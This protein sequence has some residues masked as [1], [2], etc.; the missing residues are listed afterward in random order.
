[1]IPQI[2]LHQA[3]THIKDCFSAGLSPF[4]IGDT[5]SSKTAQ[6]QQVAKELQMKLI[7]IYLDSMYEMDV[8]GYAV[9]NE[10]KGKFEY[11]PCELFPLETD[12][13][14]INPDT[15]KPYKGFLIL[16]DEFGN[17]PHSMQVAAQRVIL[18]GA[19]GSHQLHPKAFI[20]LAGNKIS[21]GTNSVPISA[22]IRSRCGIVEID[23]NSQ[24]FVDQSVAFM[25]SDGFHPAVI[26][27]VNYQPYVLMEDCSDLKNNGESPFPSSRGLEYCSNLFWKLSKKAQKQGTTLQ[28]LVAE[29]HHTLQSFIGCQFGSELVDYVQVQLP[30]VDDIVRNPNGAQLPV[31]LQSTFRVAAHIAS[32]AHSQAHAPAL[33]TYLKRMAPEMAKTILVDMVIKGKDIILAPAMVTYANT[34]K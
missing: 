27:F 11:L 7:T 31:D 2:T 29:K 33:V 16:M 26:G 13:L 9:P 34:L 3:N 21:S 30:T 25:Q 1:M 18:E 14:P 8:V 24:D 22:A 23:T 12:P 6:Y 15:G 10:V 28:A 19:I 4:L 20:G 17:C 32:N 5:G